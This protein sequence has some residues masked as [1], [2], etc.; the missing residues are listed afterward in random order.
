MNVTDLLKLLNY[1]EYDYFYHETGTG[2]G[3]QIIEEGLLV[4]GNNI[5]GTKNIAFTTIACLTPDLTETP[6]KFVSFLQNE[7]S[8]SAIREVTE[9][10]ILS[11][12][13]EIEGKIARPYGNYHDGTQYE[14]IIDSNF[15]MGVI[16][17]NNL[18]F[19]MNEE[20]EYADDLLASDD[21]KGWHNWH[22][23]VNV[24]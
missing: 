22:I 9:M 14:E 8:D 23:K 2:V 3:E 12:P 19:R 21:Y 24:I 16:N 10:V 1:E 13:K 7:K 5:I 6:E 15:V 20:F 4:D 18:T 11:S 17:L